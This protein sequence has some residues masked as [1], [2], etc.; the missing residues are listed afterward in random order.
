MNLNNKV[1]LLGHLGNN[2]EIRTLDNGNKMARMSIATYEPYKDAQGKKVDK[3]QW[4]NVVAWSTQAEYA[5]KHLAK[6]KQI[7]IEGTLRH[8]S[9]T[10]KDG[11]KR[12][13]TDVHVSNFMLIDKKAAK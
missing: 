2:P 8:N 13:T 7:M 12:Y 3:T 4:H 10:D 5:E 9:Y 1:Q 11:Q 6:G